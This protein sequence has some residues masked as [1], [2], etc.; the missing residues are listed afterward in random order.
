MDG[1]GRLGLC[2][3]AGRPR[4]ERVPRVQPC[5]PRLVRAQDVPAAGVRRRR[6]RGLA[7]PRRRAARAALPALSAA[8]V[9]ARLLARVRRVR[10]TVPAAA[11][12][13]GLG[14]ARRRALPGGRA[15]HR[16]ALASACAARFPPLR[17]RA[18]APRYALPVARS[19]P[20]SAAKDVQ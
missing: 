3:G 16:A 7:A 18:A 5:A 8:L 13:A 4:D 12:G 10:R 6:R 15:A 19:R 1:G 2:A 14:V 20:A 9:P 17:P 11:A